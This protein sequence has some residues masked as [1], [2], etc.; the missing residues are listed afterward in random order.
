M[1]CFKLSSRLLFKDQYIQVI[2]SLSK[3]FQTYLDWIA[4]T[5]YAFSAAF[6][7]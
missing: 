5:A 1:E 4:V 6:N 2:S 3:E 7:A